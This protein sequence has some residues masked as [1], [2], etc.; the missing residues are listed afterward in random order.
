M[1]GVELNFT[2]EMRLVLTSEGSFTKVRRALMAMLK[3]SCP[4]LPEL[5]ST[6][7]I[8]ILHI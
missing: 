3:L 7:P 8:R 6:I 4:T 1:F 5:S 2:S